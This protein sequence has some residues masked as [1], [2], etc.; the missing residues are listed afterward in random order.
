MQFNSTG[1][2]GLQLSKKGNTE[3][4]KQ[5]PG[6]VD[7]RQVNKEGE[8]TWDTTKTA[9][10]NVATKSW[11]GKIEGGLG[12]KEETQAGEHPRGKEWRP[13]KGKGKK[14]K[15]AKKSRKRPEVR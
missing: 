3:T 11:G 4:R 15:R 2:K 9:A 12:A 7:G 10:K 8:G 6:E 13:R 14:L 5:E 1:K